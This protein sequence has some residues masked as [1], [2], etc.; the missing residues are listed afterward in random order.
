M[1]P[2]SRQ[3]G[4]WPCSLQLIIN[5]CPHSLFPLVS[6]KPSS[7][8]ARRNIITAH[9]LPQHI[10]LCSDPSTRLLKASWKL[11]SCPQACKLTQHSEGFA[12]PLVKPVQQQRALQGDCTDTQLRQA[13]PNG[14]PRQKLRGRPRYGCERRNCRKGGILQ[15]SSQ[16]DRGKRCVTSLHPQPRSPT[17]SG[18]ARPVGSFRA[19]PGR[20]GMRCQHR[21]APPRGVAPARPPGGTAADGREAAEAAARPCSAARLASLP[22]PFP[23]S[24]FGSRRVSTFFFFF[25]YF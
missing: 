17:Y 16:Q 8:K 3:H 10:R 4:T 20:A 12:K 15:K 2:S 6:R 5:L 19:G 1:C 18:A 7:C 22:P 24:P 11:T 23:S 13:L 9:D 25:K 21:P 14:P